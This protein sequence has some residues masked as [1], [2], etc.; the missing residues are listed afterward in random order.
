MSSSSTTT[1]GGTGGFPPVPALV[2]LG[3]SST[4]P[5][6]FGTAALLK[7]AA[8]QPVKIVP[9]ATANGLQ[10]TPRT[11]V[12]SAGRP[13]INTSIPSTS[14][15][16]GTGTSGATSSPQN[17]ATVK[18]MPKN[19][20]E[21]SVRVRKIGAETN[22]KYHIMNLKK[23]VDIAKWKNI[24]M[25]REDNKKVFKA[26]RNEEEPK[27]GA[28]SEFGK[29][30]KEEARRKKFGIISK[31]Y[32]PE[33]QPWLLQEDGPAGR[34]YKGVKEGGVTE[35]TSYYIF[36]Q[37]GSGAFEA[38]P[39]ESW[40]GFTPTI[41]YNYMKEDEAEEEF[42]KRNKVM[43]RFS[44]MVRK[45]INDEKD[46][47]GDDDDEE[48]GGKK[49]GKDKAGGKNKKKKNQ[50]NLTDMDDWVEESE[51]EASGDSEGEGKKKKEEE[52]DFTVKKKPKKGEQPK[53]KKKK[54]GEEDSEEEPSEGE[55]SD[56]GDF[57]GREEDYI[58][59][60]S[61]GED[62]QEEKAADAMKGVDQQ[63]EDD[64]ED[65]ED[66]EK[67]KKKEEEEKEKEKNKKSASKDK[68]D[69]GGG[70]EKEEISDSSSSDDSDSDSDV[71]KDSLL[72][73]KKKEKKKNSSNESSRAPTPSGEAGEGSSKK[74]KSD[75]T[76]SPAVK[77][78]K[79][80][81]ANKTNS[82]DASHGSSQAPPSSVIGAAEKEGLTEDA[83]RKYLTRKPLTTIDLLAKFKNKKSAMK[84]EQLVQVMAYYL[85]RISPVNRKI[86]GKIFWSLS[87][88]GGGE[89]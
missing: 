87:K 18:P 2:K 43:S 40:Y 11:I 22:R 61:E 62:E 59:D 17:S 52:D 53:K 1:T 15:V 19:V 8:G 39:I 26:N 69:G 37:S 35:N 21:F 5:T 13:T 47:E 6:P 50:F 89:G 30:A 24:K 38:F 68:T 4:A 45:R 65:S 34:K 80:S 32:N 73:L 63:E 33:D 48:E 85:R 81:A 12:V 28:G 71:E 10:G 14:A 57:E 78:A 67:K 75:D 20:N 82:P 9:G 25:L 66:E 7:T 79:N 46:E 72:F 64:E 51:E 42:S 36:Q 41:K 84:Q 49:R 60:S 16:Q 77:K 54:K 29:D 27:F 74:R 23:Q 83:V 70:G 58:T 76:D 55:E 86:N 44:T 56:D 31:K 88:E 3:V